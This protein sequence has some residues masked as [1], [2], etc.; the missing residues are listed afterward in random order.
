MADLGIRVGDV[1]GLQSTVDRFPRLA[2]V[3]GPEGARSGDGDVDPFGIARIEKD[4]VQAHP[5]RAWL[6]FGPGAVAAQSG[7]L[8]PSLRA[9]GRA[10]QGSVLHPGVNRVRISER[11]F[12]MP[13]SLELPG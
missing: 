10:E 1:L 7:E 9:V 6:P 11:R 4:C 3:V 12:K 2:A 5:T 13:D 8:V